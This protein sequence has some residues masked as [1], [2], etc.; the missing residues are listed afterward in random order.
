MKSRMLSWGNIAGLMLVA[1]AVLAIARIPNVRGEEPAPAGPQDQQQAVEG[2]D[3]AD[4]EH[5]HEVH[6]QKSFEVPHK[7]GKR[8]SHSP[9]VVFTADGKRMVTATAEGEIVEFDAKTNKI[10]RK[11][12]LP[13]GVTSAISIDPKARFAAAVVKEGVV[14][15]D[16]ATGKTIKHDKALKTT[17]LAISPDAKRI[18]LT[19]EKQ[20]EIRE[21]KT[22]KLIK[23]VPGHEA[24][25][26]NV[27]WNG[28]GTLLGSTA[29]DGRLIIFDT[30][31]AKE[32]YQVKKGEALHALAFDPKGRFVI[33][34]GNDRQVYE[35]EWATEKEQ[36]VSKDQ[37]YWITCL[38]YSPDGGII[39][40]G[41][42]SCD[43]WLYDR[44]KRELVFHNKHHVECW[45]NSVAW[46][47]D[48]ETFLFGCRP[49]S[50]A[51]TPAV[52]TPLTVAEAAQAEAVCERRDV[53]VKRIDE[54]LAKTKDDEQKK[55]LVTYRD[56]LLELAKPLN[57][58]GAAQVNSP[59]PIDAPNVGP[60]QFELP[61]QLQANA[62][63]LGDTAQ[64]G[65]A[66]LAQAQQ[67]ADAV[68]ANV[69]PGLSIDK[70]PPKLQKVAKE[71]QRT[72]KEEVTRL[73]ANHCINKWQVK[74]K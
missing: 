27:L 39:A 61:E 35:Y 29:E 13:E 3:H 16:I 50:L 66:N 21:L 72:L 42:E 26:T 51:G 28:D 55:L 65:E 74:R 25:I 64:S 70:L 57:F 30:E 41:D 24:N 54:Q 37:P 60:F 34:G 73:H 44:E 56:S 12:K 9:S 67:V 68:T 4:H 40:V 1:V 14:V 48:N 6:L 62:T 33:Y 58:A 38:G 11:I 20:L 32:L 71:Y 31:A 45:L 5:D 22:L 63:P 36:V 23:R 18:A 15:I 8:A 17:W 43:I 53:L 52:Y 46:A 19:H 69:A 49:N 7:D 59:V 2:H 47:P 10:L